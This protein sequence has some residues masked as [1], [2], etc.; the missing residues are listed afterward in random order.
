MDWSIFVPEIQ[1]NLNVPMDSFRL[2]GH[3]PFGRDASSM[4]AWSC[5]FGFCK[6]IATS[7]YGTNTATAQTDPGVPIVYVGFGALM[8]TTSISYLSHSQVVRFLYT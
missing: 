7:L 6:D 3:V 4:L 1:N 2:H 5:S 8:L